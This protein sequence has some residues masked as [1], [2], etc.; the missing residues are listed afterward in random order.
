MTIRL[1]CL[2]SSLHFSLDISEKFKMTIE[3]FLI[4]FIR[5]LIKGQ[6]KAFHAAKRF[7]TYL[8]RGTGR[9]KTTLHWITSNRIFNI[10]CVRH[11]YKIIPK[12]LYRKILIKQGYLKK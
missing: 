9:K 8:K 4:S 7:Q 5:A 12:S 10:L 11:R 1:R 2:K 6:L 3:I